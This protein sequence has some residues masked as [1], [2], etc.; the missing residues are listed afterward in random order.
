MWKLFKTETQEAMLNL[1]SKQ[2]E[3]IELQKKSLKEK[4]EIIQMQKR[5][6]A[7]CEQQIDLEKMK[8]ETE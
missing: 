2:G 5:L 6:I 8:N 4:D 7:I 3:M 1:I